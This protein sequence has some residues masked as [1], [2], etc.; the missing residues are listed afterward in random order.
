MLDVFLKKLGQELQLT[1]PFSPVKKDRYELSF[2]PAIDV[3]MTESEEG[4]LLEGTLAPLP[5]S[6]AESF[7]LQAM[8]ANLFGR[9]TRGGA[10]GLTEEGKAL[11]LSL[12]IP[13]GA[14]YEH[15]KGRLQDFISVF[16]HWRDASSKS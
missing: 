10:L 13:K 11:T 5:S 2:D 9:G 3:A 1:A 15:F 12:A 7:L 14:S 6:G 8:E 4:V 16:D